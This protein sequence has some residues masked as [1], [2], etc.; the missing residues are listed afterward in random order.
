MRLHVKICGISDVETAV[1]ASE[2]GAD[3]VG[4]VFADSV[5][6]IEPLDA[7]RIASELPGR[8]QKVAVFLRPKSEYVERVLMDFPADIVQ[9]DHGATSLPNGP[10]LLPVFREGDDVVL[11]R[12]LEGTVSRRFH[13]EGR[14]S[15][16]G[17]TVDWQHARGHARRGLMTLAGGLD[18][19]NVARALSIVEPFGVDVSSGV[20]SA[21]GVKDPGRIRAFIEAVR[22]HEEEK[23]TT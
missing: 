3:A 10:R 15:G 9:V 23:V 12:Y 5:R 21:P 7:A 22:Q 19:T 14:S 6:R 8:V 20:E 2:A 16:M 18:P 11:A 4:F 13:Y 1:A 17:A